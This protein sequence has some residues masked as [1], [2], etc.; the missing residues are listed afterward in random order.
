MQ[1]YVN[2]PSDSGQRANL[3]QAQKNGGGRSRAPQN[4]F[5]DRTYSQPSYTQSQGQQPQTQTQS[6]SAGAEDPYAACK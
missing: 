2:F 4:D 6:A 1:W 5:G 3:S